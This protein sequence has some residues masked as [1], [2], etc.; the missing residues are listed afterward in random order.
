MNKSIKY[1]VLNKESRTVETGT[2][3]ELSNKG[4]EY[5]CGSE[6]TAYH[7]IYIHLSIDE[8]QSPLGLEVEN[9]A[10]GDLYNGINR[11]PGDFI[12]QR[13]QELKDKEG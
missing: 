9:K 2:F 1:G 13:I 8:L 3:E 6:K 4:Y 10:F 7:K 5:I 12:N 11:N